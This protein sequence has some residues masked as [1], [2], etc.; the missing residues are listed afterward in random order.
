[1][2]RFFIILFLILSFCV[3]S[4]SFSRC[5]DSDLKKGS[6]DPRSDFRLIG[7]VIH[8]E[9]MACFEDIESHKL[10]ICGMG[11]EI[12]QAYKVVG[13]K[14]GEVLLENNLD[15]STMG[16]WTGA[17]VSLGRSSGWKMF[18]L[19]SLVTIQPEVD[20]KTGDFLGLRLEKIKFDSIIKMTGI[21]EGDLVNNI[22]DQALSSLQKAIQVIKKAKK[23]NRIKVGLL[24][25]SEPITLKYD[26]PQ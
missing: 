12:G 22:N 5:E 15:K 25:N 16:L 7:T 2:T 14:R 24:R 19:S 4:A 21:K 11:D 3:V 23:L 10:I 9:P 6:M 20:T 13:I 1:M 26:F 8:K 17:V 18:Q